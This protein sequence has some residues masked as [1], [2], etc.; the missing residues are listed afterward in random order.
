MLVRRTSRSLTRELSQPATFNFDP[1]YI[2][3]LSRVYRM[4]RCFQTLLKNGGKWV[5][6]ALKVAVLGCFLRESSSPKGRQLLIHFYRHSCILYSDRNR[7]TSWLLGGGCLPLGDELSR[8]KQPK[9][10]TLRAVF[11]HFPPFWAEFESTCTFCKLCWAK[12]CKL[13]RN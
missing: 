5:K 8:R 13:D 11:T 10:A 7:I 3:L 2:L 9:T 6:T 12:V 4:Y 1:I